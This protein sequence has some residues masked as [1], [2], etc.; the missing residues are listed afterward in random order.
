MPKI[1][2]LRKPCGCNPNCTRLEGY[3]TLKHGT[4]YV[5]SKTKGH[6]CRCELCVEYIRELRASRYHLNRIR[7]GLPDVPVEE[8]GT[9]PCDCHPGCKKRRR[10]NSQEPL[11]HGTKL[12]KE[13][14]CRCDICVESF[15]PCLCNE[16]CKIRYNSKPVVHG[17]RYTYMHHKCRCRPCVDANNEHQRS[18]KKVIQLQRELGL[19]PEL[20]HGTQNAYTNWGCR[21]ELCSAKNSETCREYKKR[22]DSE[23]IN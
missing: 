12:F 8:R 5:Y 18:R 17:V 14:G 9:R 6:G 16:N 20:E 3:K 1:T 2:K 22:R 10:N 4:M 15:V 23:K 13:H 11:K 19:L 7:K 21:C